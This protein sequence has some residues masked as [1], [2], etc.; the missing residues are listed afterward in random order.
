MN[1]KLRNLAI[2]VSIAFAAIVLSQDSFAQTQ[3]NPVLEEVTGTWCQY[4][5]C[6]HDVMAQIKANIPNAIMI[7]YHG[8]ANISSDPFSFFFGNSIIS[9]FGFTSYP[10]AVIDRVSGIQSRG[11]WSGLM[12]NRNSVPATVAIDVDRSYNKLTREFSA[13]ID[14]TALANLTGQYNFNV[15]LLEDGLVWNQ[16]GN[17]SA[18]CIGGPNY[19]HKHVVRDMMNGALG[20]EIINGSWSVNEVITKTVNRTIPHPGGS[21]PDIT[22]DS[23]RIVVLVYKVGSPLSSNAEIQQAIEMDLTSPD[24]VITLT[25][26]S[27]DMIIENNGIAEFTAVV[28][29]E[30]LLNDTYYVD[31]TMSAPAGWTADFTTLN[32]TFPIG[33][34]DSVDVL[35]GDTLVVDMSV[36]PNILNGFG[37]ITVQF[38]SKN[39][40]NI[41]GS[42]NFRVVTTTGVPGL[43]IDA[44][45][46]GYGDLV[47]NG[48]EQEFEYPFG[49]VSREALTTSVDLTNFTLICWSSGNAYPVLTE[50]NVDALISF[51]GNGGRLL[52]NGQNIGEDIFDASGQSQFAQSFYNNYLHSNY[53][54]QWAQSFS[55][56]GLPG[57]PISDQL[58]FQLN[59]V[60]EKDPDEFIPF[61]ANA[62]SLFKVG[63][64]SRYNSI[65]AD[66]GVNRV[67]YLGFGLEQINDQ[68]TKDSIVARSVR[69]L[70]NGI[71][72]DNSDKGAI[73]T[74]YSLDQNYPNPFNP[75]TTISYSIPEESQVSLKIYDV[76]G[77]EVAEL[78]NGRQLAGMYNVNFDASSLASGTYF[79]KLT[80]GNFVSVKKM[81]LIK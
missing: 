76:M 39:D 13:T 67:V 62:A 56:N 19:I 48:L 28:R 8:P 65:R 42:S 74:S 59:S 57:D 27:E 69:W 36:S 80:A 21:G 66:D 2:I 4:C 24:Y 1:I 9:T 10:T 68:A 54:S 72:L 51:L 16:V 55:F 71:V 61:D 14:F 44:S 22:P 37:D 49:I 38:T 12:N 3:R 50:D 25:S 23:C 46:E 5:P 40:P 15:I 53:L 11:V 32:G 35:S 31:V 81:V 33:V 45:G 77:S 41:T 75:A 18:G 78:V 6:G 30:G 17:V 47:T 60:Y 43:V 79:Y 52:I 73:I 64:S 29:N 63:V 58:S 20:Q 26:S 7:G 34:R 70:M